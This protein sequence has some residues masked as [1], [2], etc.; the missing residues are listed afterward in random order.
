[1]QR[2]SATFEHWNWAKP[3]KAKVGVKN[4]NVPPFIDPK[5]KISQYDRRFLVKMQTSGAFDQC[6]CLIESL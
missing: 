4:E 5:S 6:V 3:I 1:M 2:S